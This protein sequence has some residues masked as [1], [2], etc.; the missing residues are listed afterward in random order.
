[1]AG[2]VGFGYDLEGRRIRTD[3]SGH[4]ERTW[5]ELSDVLNH[6]LW[7]EVDKAVEAYLEHFYGG[8]PDYAMLAKAKMRWGTC[9]SAA[10]AVEKY[11]QGNAMDAGYVHM[12]FRLSQAAR[13]QPLA[14]LG[15]ER[16]TTACKYLIRAIR[17]DSGSGYDLLADMWTGL[18]DKRKCELGCR[19]TERDEVL[20]Q[21]ETESLL[22]LAMG[23][24]PRLGADSPA[25]S[26]LAP[27]LLRHIATYHGDSFRREQME[28]DDRRVPSPS[29][30]VARYAAAKAAGNSAFACDVWDDALVAYSRGLF[31]CRC[32]VAISAV[33]TAV[34]FSNRC[35]TYLRRDQ[36]G[37]AFRALADARACVSLR[38]EWHKAWFRLG[39]A[40]DASG[41]ATAEVVSALAK[42]LVIDPTDKSLRAAM[43]SALSSQRPERPP[44]VMAATSM[45][46]PA[47]WPCPSA[48]VL[49]AT[50]AE[51][52]EPWDDSGGGY[53]Q[54][55]QRDLESLSRMGWS[56][57]V[58]LQPGNEMALLRVEVDRAR[59]CREM[60]TYTHS[61][62]HEDAGRL[63][64]KVFF[65]GDEAGAIDQLDNVLRY[66]GY[67]DGDDGS[68]IHNM[69]VLALLLRC[70]E[71]DEIRDLQ[72]AA[73]LYNAILQRVDD[74]SSPRFGEGGMQFMRDFT[75]RHGGG[76]GD[77]GL[78]GL[79]VG[80]Y[81]PPPPAVPERAFTHPGSR[82]V[83]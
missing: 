76:G 73:A 83:E 23:G 80:G 4:D 20:R 65:G 38:P 11:K 39:T 51:L 58:C 66:T 6:R 36:R 75:S 19:N 25:S 53:G 54:S 60:E 16:Y 21:C 17:N 24:H 70:A 3:Y 42:G 56:M 12:P 15:P 13:P 52:R 32:T 41:G 47:P 78:G 27:E 79:G 82:I 62:V 18:T 37:D 30:R 69:C 35:V 81:I 72:K 28:L 57:D 34:L 40:I 55:R 9:P 46:S 50:P 7:D 5:C 14:Y 67:D 48:Q 29:E 49:A 68:P 44:P 2:V 8:S 74:P 26:C 63:A 71:D 10:A 31:E 64:C 59:F 22:A 43:R 33:E 1:M 61:D 77:G 45:D